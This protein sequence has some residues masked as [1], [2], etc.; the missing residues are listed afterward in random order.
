MKRKGYGGYIER[1]QS[2]KKNIGNLFR[3]G[4]TMASDRSGG[5]EKQTLGGSS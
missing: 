3:H 2:E 4:G 5:G 1:H